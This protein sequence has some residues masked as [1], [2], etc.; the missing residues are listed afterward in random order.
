MCAVERYREFAPQDMEEAARLAKAWAGETF[1]GNVQPGGGPVSLL[2]TV[3]WAAGGPTCV[4][5]SRQ[6]SRLGSAAA[7]DHL[8]AMLLEDGTARVKMTAVERA[9]SRG[10]WGQLCEAEKDKRTQAIGWYRAPSSTLRRANR[11]RTWRGCCVIRRN[12]KAKKKRSSTYRL[13][14]ARPI[15]CSIC[16]LRRT[17]ESTPEHTL[18][19][20]ALS[21]RIRPG[22]HPEEAGST[23][24]ELEDAAE[25]VARTA[26]GTGVGRVL[27]AAADVERLKFDTDREKNKD[28]RSE[29]RRHLTKTVW[30]SKQSSARGVGDPAQFQLLWQRRTCCSTSGRTSELEESRSELREEAARRIV[31]LRRTRPTR[32]GASPATICRRVCW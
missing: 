30:N 29:A 15:N 11:Y 28:G 27:L 21:P 18:A 2:E 20:L 26:T 23:R 24:I 14:K 8:E 32:S 6:P 10:C 7:R 4:Y 19:A 17:M 22:Q 1:A 9:K 25:D 13:S 31:Q 12:R 3:F 5:S 16:S